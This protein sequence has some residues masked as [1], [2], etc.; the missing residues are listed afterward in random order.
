[1]RQT[2]LNMTYIAAAALSLVQSGE[3]IIFS[4][5]IASALLMREPS[6]LQHPLLS[7]FCM[8]VPERMRADQIPITRGFN[9]LRVREGDESQ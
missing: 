3:L 8:K 2:A 4:G 6:M 1:M 5:N 9:L 7:L